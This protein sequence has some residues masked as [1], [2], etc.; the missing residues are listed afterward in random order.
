[1]TNKNSHIVKEIVDRYK[2]VHNLKTYV[3]A[4]ERLGISQSALSNQIS[5]GSLNIDLLIESSDPDVNLHWLIKGEGPMRINQNTHKAYVNELIVDYENSVD[6]AMK[7]DI[8]Q[9]DLLEF[10]LT[11]QAAVL[12]FLH[13]LKKDDSRSSDDS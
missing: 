7:S 11:Q 12:D 3:D 5:R 9:D 10:L 6:E 1:L 13:K 4:A 8:T 2:K